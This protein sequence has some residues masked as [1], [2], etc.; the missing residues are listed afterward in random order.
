MFVGMIYSNALGHFRKYAYNFVTSFTP[1]VA[2]SSCVNVKG[3]FLTSMVIKDSVRYDLSTAYCLFAK[4]DPIGNI[5]LCTQE[6][7]QFASCLNE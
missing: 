1:F 2:D 4:L 3:A 6:Q 7:V 5:L